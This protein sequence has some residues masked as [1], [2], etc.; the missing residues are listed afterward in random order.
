MSVS[1]Q[2]DINALCPSVQFRWGPAWKRSVCCKSGV[3]IRTVT[4]REVR[5]YSLFLAVLEV[6]LMR[7]IL[8]VPEKLVLILYP[9]LWSQHYSSSHNSSRSSRVLGPLYAPFS[10]VYLTVFFKG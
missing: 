1:L 5:C 3:F 9:W 2:R 8:K 10:S 6:G 4:S 7:F